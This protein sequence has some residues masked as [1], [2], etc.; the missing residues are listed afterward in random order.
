MYEFHLPDM[1]CGHCSATVTKTV[2]ALDAE[3]R[4]EIDL[5]THRLRVQSS[6]SREQLAAALNEA[7]YAPQADG[8]H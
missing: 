2:R 4:I 5:P 3:A 1:T 7:G 8:A 6:R